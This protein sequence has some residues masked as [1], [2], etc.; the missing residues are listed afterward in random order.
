MIGAARACFALPLAL[1]VAGCREPAAVA[2]E[3]SAMLAELAAAGA[4]VREA[5]AA[6]DRSALLRAAERAAAIGPL[7]P[8]QVY[9][10]ACAQA[11][12]GQGDAAIAT[13]DRLAEAGVAFDLHRDQDLA[14]L[15]DRA[16]FVRLARKMERQ[17][18]AVVGDSPI[19]FV[20]PER[21]SIAEAVVFDRST[22]DYYVSAAYAHKILRVRR[23]D[24][25]FAV[26]ELATAERSGLASPTGIA[27]DPHRRLLWTC[28][29]TQPQMRGAAPDEPRRGEVLAL[30]LDDGRVVERQALGGGAPDHACDSLALGPDGEVYASDPPGRTIWRIA[31]GAAAATLVAPGL[32]PAPQDMA[33]FPDGLALYVADHARGLFRIDLPAGALVWLA[34]PPDLAL[35]GIDGL[36]P[37]RRAGERW[38]IALQNG[39]RPHRILALRLDDTGGAITGGRVLAQ[40]VP[41]WDE[42]TLGTVVRDEL[43]YVGRSQWR[44]LDPDG[45]LTRLDELAAPAVFALPLT[46]GEP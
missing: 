21:D 17:A 42:P 40:N 7:L 34:A 46:A 43:I 2:P 26:T 45:R 4:A 35:G 8:N 15:A 36:E 37:W 24:D 11:L 44:L 27:I 28:S 38:L 31:R 41:G 23:K 32:L 33:L 25:G 10:L 29:S 20:L 12:A 16:D 5:H 18:A 1:V 13:L 3:A 14:P 6:G 22:G 9:N 39:Q 30:S 19:R